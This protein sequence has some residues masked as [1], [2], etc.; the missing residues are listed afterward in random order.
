MLINIYKNWPNDVCV[1]GFLSL[2]KCMDMR[3]SLMDKNEDIIA[4]FGLMKLNEI[5]IGFR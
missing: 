3:K 1:D 2:D 4:S 5:I